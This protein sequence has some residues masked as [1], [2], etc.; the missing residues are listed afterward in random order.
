MFD[1]YEKCSNILNDLAEGQDCYRESLTLTTR[2]RE[3]I[4]FS[5]HLGDSD[6]RRSERAEIIDGLNRLSLRMFSKP[7]LE[8][9]PEQNGEMGSLLGLL[10]QLARDI[11]EILS[12]LRG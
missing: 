7:F 12:L 6:L 2:L 5:R 8:L 11:R 3:N 9:C 4:Q 10:Q 1:T